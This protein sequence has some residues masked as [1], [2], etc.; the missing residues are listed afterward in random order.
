MFAKANPSIELRPQVLNACF[1][2]D[3]MF[4]ENDPDVFSGTHDKCV[5]READDARSSRKVQAQEIFIHDVPNQWSH[6]RP[7]RSATWHLDR[8][9]PGPGSFLNG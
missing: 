7:L 9:Y 4:S 1:Q 6:P 5:I 3:L 2:L 8:D